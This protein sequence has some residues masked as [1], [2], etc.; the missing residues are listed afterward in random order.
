[1]SQRENVSEIVVLKVGTP[2][3]ASGL[4]LYRDVWTD[5][6]LPWVHIDGATEHHPRNLPSPMA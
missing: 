6:A 1:M 4:T 2:D 3:D 5:S